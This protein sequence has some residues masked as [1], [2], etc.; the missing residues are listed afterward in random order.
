MHLRCSNAMEPIVARKTWRTVE[1]IHGAVYFAAGAAEIYGGLG[2]R[3]ESGYFASRAAPLGAVPAEVV[4]A[5]FFN[6]NPAFVRRAMAGV[7]DTTTPGAVSGARLEVVDRMLRQMLGGEVLASPEI[8]AAADLLRAAAERASTRPEGRPLFAGHASLPW[9]DA[10]DAHLVVWHAQALLR[11]FRGDAHI[12]AL[13]VEGVSGLEALVLHAATGEVPA[14]VL[15]GSRQWSSDEWDAAVEALGRRG[16]LDGDANLTDAGRTHRQWVEERT[17]A[18][19]VFAYEAL[20]EDGCAELR[21]LARPWSQAIV[22]A[23]GLRPH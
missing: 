13:T 21:R 4:I 12:A 15:R 8:R 10:N 3:Q 7:W 17:D 1:P 16:W 11:E 5:A 22:G 2:L 23:G 18:Q 20:G 6:F 14:A 9:P 19:S